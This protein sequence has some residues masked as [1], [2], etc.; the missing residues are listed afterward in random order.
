MYR[1]SRTV[2]QTQSA[3]QLITTSA[4]SA[5]PSCRLLI[6]P[7]FLFLLSPSFF[8]LPAFYNTQTE[9]DRQDGRACD[10]QS[11]R[12]VRHPIPPPPHGFSLSRGGK[13]SHRERERGYGGRDWGEEE[14]EKKKREN[15]GPVVALHGEGQNL[16]IMI[17]C[18]IRSLL[19]PWLRNPCC[20]LLCC[21][22]HTVMHPCSRAL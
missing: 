20:F 19:P 3:T 7:R 17:S 6:F 8:P 14:E 1:R 21:P 2:Y 9:T 10:L 5:T 12:S 16:T 4:T 18:L 13:T 22:V 15:Q 11:N